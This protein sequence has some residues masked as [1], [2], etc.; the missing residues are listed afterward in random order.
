MPR[1]AAAVAG[2][3]VNKSVPGASSAQAASLAA[4]MIPTLQS[5]T[6][7]AARKAAIS[8]DPKPKKSELASRSVAS[9]DQLSQRAGTGSFNSSTST[10][11]ADKPSEGDSHTELQSGLSESIED[12][13]SKCQESHDDV[14]ASQSDDNNDKDQ[15]KSSGNEESEDASGDEDARDADRSDNDQSDDDQ[16]DDQSDEDPSDDDQSDDEAEDSELP[17]VTGNLDTGD[18]TEDEP[19][20]KR[21]TKPF[22]KRKS[23]LRDILSHFMPKDRLVTLTTKLRNGRK[24]AGLVDSFSAEDKK[25]LKDLVNLV[26]ANS[27]TYCTFGGQAFQMLRFE[28]VK[29]TAIRGLLTAHREWESTNGLPTLLQNIKTITIHQSFKQPFLEWVGDLAL[30]EEDDDGYEE[31]NGLFEI[32]FTEMPADRDIEV[33]GSRYM[34]SAMEKLRAILPKLKKR[35]LNTWIVEE[36]ADENERVT[37]RLISN[38]HLQHRRVGLKDSVSFSRTV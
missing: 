23:V 16:S 3:P 19:D 29:T 17:N 9:D 35:K 26:C 33:A 15:E 36:E 22:P 6:R 37:V 32:V 11:L 27:I 14:S 5:R 13:G 38:D 25:L 7:S 18:N 10:L 1:L 2:R 34:P 31:L 8:S 20:L 28:F 24:H 21:N 30:L 4:D 12:G